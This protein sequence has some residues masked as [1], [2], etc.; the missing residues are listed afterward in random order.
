MNLLLKIDFDRDGDYDEDFE[1]VSAHIRRV[2]FKRG[3]ESSFK[4]FSPIA[5]LNLVRNIKRFRWRVFV[6]KT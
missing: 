3:R 4:L 2:T 5:S 1:D 6:K